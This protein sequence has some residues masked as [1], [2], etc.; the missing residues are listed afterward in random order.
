MAGVGGDSGSS[1]GDVLSL[2]CAR[3]GDS[4]V[5]D[6]ECRRWRFFFDFL[7]LSLDVLMVLVERY[8]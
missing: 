6:G 2:F 1:I 5:A 3:D 8:K 7:R 4:Y